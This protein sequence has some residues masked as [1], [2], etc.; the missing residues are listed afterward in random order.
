MR[1]VLGA[2][3]FRLTYTESDPHLRSESDW[4]GEDSEEFRR[5]LEKNNGCLLTSESWR[6]Q[7]YNQLD[8]VEYVFDFIV[9]RRDKT[10]DYLAVLECVERA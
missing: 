9:G 3:Q 5:I 4:P 6:Y 7:P 10:M 2:Y 1:A 8:H